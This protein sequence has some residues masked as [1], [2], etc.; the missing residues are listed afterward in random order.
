MALNKA[1]G[2]EGYPVETVY[3]LPTGME[4]KDHGPNGGA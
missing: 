1:V 2:F 3:K 4:L